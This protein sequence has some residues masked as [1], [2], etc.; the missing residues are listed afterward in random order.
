MNI[1]YSCWQKFNIF[2]KNQLKN[3]SSNWILSSKFHEDIY[4]DKYHYKNIED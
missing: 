3:K 2:R 4:Y 1:L